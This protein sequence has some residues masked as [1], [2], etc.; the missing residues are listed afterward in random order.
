MKPTRQIFGTNENENIRM[1]GRFVEQSIVK[2]QA[3]CNRIIVKLQKSSG[4]LSE[5]SRRAALRTNLPEHTRW[6]IGGILYYELRIVCF[7]KEP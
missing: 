5:P 6:F 1:R 7:T 3:L 4:T 2:L